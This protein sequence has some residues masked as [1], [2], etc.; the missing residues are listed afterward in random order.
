[1]LHVVVTCS[2]CRSWIGT[3]G[4]YSIESRGSSAQ[5]GSD[6][7]L[8]SC[9]MEHL[10]EWSMEKLWLLFIQ[11]LYA[12]PKSDGSMVDLSFPKCKGFV[13]IQSKGKDLSYAIFKWDRER[14]NVSELVEI[15]TVLKWLLSDLGLIARI[16]GYFG[17]GLAGSWSSHLHW[18]LEFG[19]WIAYHMIYLEI[20]DNGYDFHAI[21]SIRI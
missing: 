3:G 14:S 12:H 20:E 7:S 8:C 18:I 21:F 19:I 17:A 4:P 5:G 2:S 1:M 9:K 13:D 10:Q 6:F 11:G 16:S 15:C